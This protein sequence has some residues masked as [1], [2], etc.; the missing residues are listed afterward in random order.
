MGRTPNGV[1][2]ARGLSIG[3]GRRSPLSLNKAPAGFPGCC[4]RWRK[5]KTAGAMAPAVW[6]LM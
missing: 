3:L 4:E 5:T 2:V 6:V 1:R